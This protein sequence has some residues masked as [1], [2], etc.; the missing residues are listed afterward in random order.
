M[1]FVAEKSTIEAYLV[2]NYTSTL[3]KY[4][5]DEMNDTSVNE[6]IR[7][8]T[9]NAQASQVSLGDNP[10]FRYRGVLFVQIF[11]RPD[12]GSGRALVIADLM[13]SLFRAK[14]ISDMTFFVPR[15]QKVGVNKDWYQVNVSIEFSREE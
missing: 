15:I 4:E 6:W 11:V 10:L 9:Q 1:S 3:V 2:S 12:I 13:T 14:R 8:S 5:N 7:V